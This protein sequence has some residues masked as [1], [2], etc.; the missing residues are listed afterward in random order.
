MRDGK[1]KTEKFQNS[2]TIV[3]GKK[4][5]CPKVSKITPHE[6]SSQNHT[7]PTNPETLNI[8]INF[9]ITESGNI[10]VNIMPKCLL[11]NNFIFKCG[12]L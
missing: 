1:S 4:D 5:K 3:L 11:H 10:G 2:S 12:F 6:G 8:L 7:I 9:N